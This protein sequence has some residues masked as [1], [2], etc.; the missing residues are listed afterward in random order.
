[1]DELKRKII[2]IIAEECSYTGLSIHKARRAALEQGVTAAE[3]E[4]YFS[5]GLSDI[6]QA[7]SEYIDE[8]MTQR[9]DKE[10]ICPIRVR[11]KIAHA[12]WIRFEEMD[13]YPEMVRSC[14]RYWSL[15]APNEAGSCIWKSADLIWIWAGDTAE[16]YN[17]YTKRGLLSSV[18]ISTTLYWL[19][20]SSDN[21]EKSK[22]FLNRRINNVLSI[23]KFVGKPLSRLMGIA[24]KFKSSINR[25][26]SK[27]QNEN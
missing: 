26:E 27:K 12:T 7:F 21:R 22:A 3:Y 1:M 8:K 5:D 6:A 25:A 17:H 10:K 15:Q 20:D 11:D 2:K 18:I 13:S 24:D 19:G 9:L 16:D 4:L 23:G 14:A